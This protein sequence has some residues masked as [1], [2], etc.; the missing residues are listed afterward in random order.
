VSAIALVAMAGLAQTGRYTVR[1]GDTLS[2]IAARNGT[3]VQALVA[4]NSIRNPNLIV[5]GQSLSMDGGS[6][7]TTTSTSSDSG[8]AIVVVQPG[9]TLATVAARTGVPADTIMRA[10]GLRPTSMLYTGGQLLLAPRN[11]P[12]STALT[13]CPVA[14]AHFMDDWGFTRTDTGFHQGNDMMAKRGTPVVAP[15]SGT[16]TNVVGSISGNQFRLVGADGTLYIGA[17]LDKFGKTGKVKAGDVIGYV[18]DTGDAKGGPTH[19]HF[20]I[21]PGS[22]A[23]VNPYYVLVAAC[24]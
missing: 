21:H 19:L 10:N 23:A 18:G 24:R 20:E 3:T 17:H 15:V 11:M 6:T 14:S 4:A 5:I 16:V 8:A 12:P 7:A 22:G 13:R 1:R 9:D 2:A